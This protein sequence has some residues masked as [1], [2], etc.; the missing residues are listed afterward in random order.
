MK[1]II[2]LLV[3]TSLLTSCIMVTPMR[4]GYGMRR[5]YGC[6]HNVNHFHPIKFQHK[7]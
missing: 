4:G 5:G 6:M 1:A 7:R 3:V 2:T